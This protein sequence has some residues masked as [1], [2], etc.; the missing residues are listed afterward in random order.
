MWSAFDRR[1]LE[2]S[3]SASSIVADE[4]RGRHE[5]QIDAST[6]YAAV[7]VGARGLLSS[8]PFTV[9]GHR[10]HIMY[11]PNGDCAESQ[12]YVSVFLLLDGDV[13][14]PVTARCRLTP[15]GS[16]AVQ[17]GGAA[18]FH[19]PTWFGVHQARHKGA[20]DSPSGATSSPSTASARR[21]RRRR[22]PFP[23]PTCASTSA[24]SSGAGGAP[25]SCSRSAARRSPRT[26]ACSWHGLRSS[27]SAELL[28][29]ASH[30][31][32]AAGAIRVDGV[33]PPA[34]RALLRYAYTDS[35]QEMDKDEEDAVLRNLLAAA[36]MYLLP[37][38]KLICEDKLRR[39]IDAGTVQTTLELAERHHCDRLKEAC[40]HF[41]GA[42]GNL[43]AVSH[44]HSSW[45]VTYIQTRSVI[46]SL[47]DSQLVA[48]M[49]AD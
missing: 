41:L 40:L 25:T 15:Q 33:D 8:S 39:L 7:P 12:G 16:G 6:L 19:E 17:T 37:R 48:A 29:T 38:L 44:G 47:N 36:D 13:A 26:G 4:E 27:D 2:R 14:K 5:L 31:A 34:F 11:Y 21:R 1:K 28:S 32:V 35:L 45:P 49:T 20:V 9:G 30:G 24:T 18:R 46:L 42:P 3:R 10:W 23:P 43:R 22:P